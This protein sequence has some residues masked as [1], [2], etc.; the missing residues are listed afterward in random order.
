[1]IVVPFYFL[2]GCRGVVSCVQ[3]KRRGAKETEF[4]GFRPEHLERV[5]LAATLLSRLIE[6]KLLS[7]AVAWTNE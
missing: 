4:P 7:Q 5:Q 1:M 2:H 3:L 6:Y